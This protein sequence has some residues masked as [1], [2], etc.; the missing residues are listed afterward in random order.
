M[1]SIFY[2]RKELSKKLLWSAHS[3]SAES[4]ILLA[5]GGPRITLHRWWVN[6]QALIIS[7]LSMPLHH[8]LLTLLHSSTFQVVLK[9][10]KDGEG[11][12]NEK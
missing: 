12:P 9:F 5:S 8:Q 4:P 2:E 3:T 7:A 6:L 11:E 1:F 10:G